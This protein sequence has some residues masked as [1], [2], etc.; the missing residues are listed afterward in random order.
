MGGL[1]DNGVDAGTMALLW[2]LKNIPLGHLGGFCDGLILRHFLCVF[3]P[4][5]LDNCGSIIA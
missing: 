5:R 2:I 3:E 1:H 4:L